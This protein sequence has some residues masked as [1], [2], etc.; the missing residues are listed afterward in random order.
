MQNSEILLS[1]F[2]DEDDP[3]GLVLIFSRHRNDK[4]GDM[5]WVGS[6]MPTKTNLPG[7]DVS[8]KSLADLASKF[9]E[10]ITKVD[11]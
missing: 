4:T 5:E 2:L 10:F 7:V 9:E 1:D 6:L 8:E 11:L 3:K